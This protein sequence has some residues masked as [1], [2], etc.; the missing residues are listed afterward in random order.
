MIAFNKKL[1]KILEFV[2]IGVLLSGL[3]LGIL[4]KENHPKAASNRSADHDYQSERRASFGPS[5]EIERPTVICSDLLE[6]DENTL[7]FR[8]LTEVEVVE[9]MYV[10]CGGIF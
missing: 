6:E 4:T 1:R 10:G 8:E 2:S 9:C 7:V 5:V 3:A